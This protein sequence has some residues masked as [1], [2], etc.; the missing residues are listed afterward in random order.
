MSLTKWMVSKGGG[1]VLEEHLGFPDGYEFFGSKSRG[2]LQHNAL[3]N[4]LG[5]VW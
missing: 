2:L 3:Q 4:V 5:Q 1:H